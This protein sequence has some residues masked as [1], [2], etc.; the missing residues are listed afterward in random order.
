[1]RHSDRDDAVLWYRGSK[2]KRKEKGR[3]EDYAIAPWVRFVT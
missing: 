1:M 2:G 3:S